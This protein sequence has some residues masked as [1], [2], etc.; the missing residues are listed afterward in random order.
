MKVEKCSN[1]QVKTPID[2]KQDSQNRPVNAQYNP[3][4]GSGM[5]GVLGASGNFMQWVENGGFLVSFLIQDCLGMT[6]PRVGAAFLRD[7]EVTGHYNIQEGFEVLGREGL[8]GPCMMAVAPIMFAL[9]AIF[10]KS[11]SVNSQLIKRFGNSLKEIIS[12]PEFDKALLKNKEKFK[13]EFFRKN[14]TKILQDT[15][16]KENVKNESIDYI[17][18]QIKNYEHIPADAKL[19]KFFGKSKYRKQCMANIAEHI[20]NIRYNTSANLDM[21]QKL[22][23]GSDT[24]KDIKAFSTKDTIDAMIKYSNDAISLN[25]NLDKLDAAAADNIK[26]S[27]IAKRFITN[28]STMA[29]TLGVL[30]ILPKIYAKNDIAPGAQTANKLRE[31]KEREYELEKELE[32]DK[33]REAELRQDLEIENAAKG[34]PAFKGKAPGKGPLSRFGKFLSDHTNENFSSEL[35]YNGHNFTNTLM[36]GLSLFG[37][38]FPRGLRAYNRAQTDD[39][40]GKK[41]LTELYEILIRDITSSLSVVFVVPMLTRAF[42]TSYEKHSGFVL[43]HK[44]RSMSKVKTLL[45]L[46]NPYSKAHVLTNS[47]ISSLYNN[48]DGIDKMRNFCKYIDK[49]EGDLQKILSKSETVNTL[50]NEKTLDL[51]KLKNLDRAEKNKKI[52]EFFEKFEQQAEKLGKP[53]DKE[54][55]NKLVR[56][57]M[58]SVKKPKGNGITSFAR[59]LNSIPAMLT[60]VFISPYILG[61]FIPRLTYANTRRI[62]E[63]Q[64]KEREAILNRTA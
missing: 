25:K 7:K 34:E 48:V 21:L 19:D 47:E 24:I 17:L 4:F 37:L 8:T 30:S 2:N 18:K 64:E 45:D 50:F 22:K 54:S 15:L 35:E 9:A 16:G 27:S 13:E 10:G 63:K 58:K 59:G 5:S 53:K 11:T 49:N 28:V 6:M 1:N 44:D 26:N 36:A 32:H 20:D 61:W 52:I 42:V 38:L 46:L 55:L 33:K 23:V 57:L 62:H 14:I 60:M 3:S 41:D 31:L 56:D 51:S 40:T 29:A 43:M 39:V 12:K